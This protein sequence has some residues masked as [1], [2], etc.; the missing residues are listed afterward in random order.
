MQEKNDPKI[1]E[2][3][4]KKQEWPE[5]GK[6]GGESQDDMGKKGGDYSDPDKKREGVDVGEDKP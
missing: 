3:P 4:K 1:G 2:D 5:T 6:Q